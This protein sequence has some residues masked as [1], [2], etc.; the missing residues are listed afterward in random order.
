MGTLACRRPGPPARAPPS[1]HGA[2]SQCPPAALHDRRCVCGGSG[3]GLIGMGPGAPPP[4][5]AP[6]AAAAGG[7]ASTGLRVAARS[8]MGCPA[9]RCLTFLSVWLGTRR[10][11]DSSWR[12][13]SSRSAGR[14]APLPSCRCSGAGLRVPPGGGAARVPTRVLIRWAPRCLPAPP[15]ACCRDAEL[16]AVRSVTAQGKTIVF[17]LQPP[18]AIA[19]ESGSGRTDAACQQLPAAW[20]LYAWATKVPWSG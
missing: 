15:P 14:A 1:S 5:A 19:S 8:R 12:R 4:P 2:A 6:A 7:C 17:Q 18:A 11:P 9:A 16:P 10:A 20:H 13:V 3:W